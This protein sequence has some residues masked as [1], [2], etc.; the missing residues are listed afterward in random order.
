MLNFVEIARTTAEIW[1]FFDFLR[2]R[3]LLS[4]IFDISNFNGRNGQG[5]ELH[6]RAKFHQ[7]RLNRG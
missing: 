6:H 7:N 1:R 4:L 5:V 3:P 2:W